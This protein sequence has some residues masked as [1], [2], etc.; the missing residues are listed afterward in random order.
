MVRR[1]SDRRSG[2]R[3]PMMVME[4]PLSSS[5]AAMVC[6]VFSLLLNNIMPLHFIECVVVVLS[7]ALGVLFSLLMCNLSVLL[8]SLLSN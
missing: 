1:V 8:F 6:F 3:P 2:S 4:L 5:G 7:L